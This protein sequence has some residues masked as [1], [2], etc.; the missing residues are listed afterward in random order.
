MSERPAA[1]VTGGAIRVGF[2]FARTLAE[3][4]HDI[5]IHYNSSAAKAEEAAAA[6]RALGVE[7]AIFPCD[8]L[9]GE[10]PSSLIDRV[11]EVFPRLSVLVNCASIYNAAPVAETSMAMLQN[12]FMVNFFTPFLLSGAFARRVERGNIVNILDNKIAFQQYQ[13]GAYLSAKKALAELTKMT[14]MEFAPRIRVNGI[15]PGVIMPGVTRSDDYIRW[16]VQG[17]PL[18]RQGAVEELGKALLYILDNE[19][20]TGQHLFVD[21]GEGLFHIGQNAEVYRPE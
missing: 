13:Y 15:A 6:I 21:G 11:V 12:E 19:Y 16:R 14:A 4:G 1:L 3:R 2:H 5:A 18:K 10:D 9:S 8:F 7:C 20:I 17:I